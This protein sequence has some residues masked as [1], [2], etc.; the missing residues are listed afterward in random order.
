MVVLRI[1][2]LRRPFVVSGGTVGRAGRSSRSIPKRR[3]GCRTSR[4]EHGAPYRGVSW[5]LH[6]YRRTGRRGPG[7][8]PSSVPCGDLPRLPRRPE[9]REIRPDGGPSPLRGLDARTPVNLASQSLS[10][11]GGLGPGTPAAVSGGDGPRATRAPITQLRL[12]P[13]RETSPGRGTD[14]SSDLRPAR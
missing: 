7:G 13:A 3:T 9:L 1:Q 5:V 10:C 8:R 2:Y 11:F 14:L 12:R 4:C 6:T